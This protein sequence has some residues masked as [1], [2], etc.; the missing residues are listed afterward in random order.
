MLGRV[1]SAQSAN[2]F[3]A[4]WAAKARK[5][6]MQA[7]TSNGWSLANISQRRAVN[8]SSALT[9]RIAKRVKRAHLTHVRNRSNLFDVDCCAIC[10]ASIPLRHIH[11]SLLHS[12]KRNWVSRTTYA[13]LSLHWTSSSRSASD[14]PNGKGAYRLHYFHAGASL[15]RLNSPSFTHSSA[16]SIYR[17]RSWQTR[18]AAA[19]A[20]RSLS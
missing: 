11:S 17:T 19:E 9:V 15:Y 10:I 8:E 1:S 13:L 16:V 12:H 4:S 18:H 2:P 5:R 20:T 14:I 3:R 7:R 6:R